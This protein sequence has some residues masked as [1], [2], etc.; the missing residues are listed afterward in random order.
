LGRAVSA[1]R[2]HGRAPSSFLL[3][4]RPCSLGRE[5]SIPAARAP[6]RSRRR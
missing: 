6:V 5:L 4:L 3:D 1:H 2:R